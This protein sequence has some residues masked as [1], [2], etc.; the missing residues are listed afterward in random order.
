M[1]P[2]VVLIFNSRLDLPQVDSHNFFSGY[3]KISLNGFF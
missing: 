3:F 2:A 1:V